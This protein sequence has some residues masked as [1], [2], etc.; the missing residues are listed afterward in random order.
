MSQSPRVSIRQNQRI[1]V[2]APGPGSVSVRLVGNSAG[3]LVPEGVPAKGFTQVN[4]A[5]VADGVGSVAAERMPSLIRVF[6]C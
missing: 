3:V 5:E 4:G 2:P 1:S 6:S